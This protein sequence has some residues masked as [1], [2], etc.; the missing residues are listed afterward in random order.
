MTTGARA[1][2]RDSAPPASLLDAVELH[3]RA[4]AAAAARRVFTVPAEGAEAALRSASRSGARYDT[5]LSFMCTPQVASLE[6][7][8]AAIE[9]ILADEGWIGMVEPAGIDRG[10]L[11]GWLTARLRRQL[12]PRRATGRDAV[13]AVRA[14][15]LVITDI[16]RREARS[17]PPAWRQ[18]VVLRARRATP[19]PEGP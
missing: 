11:P 18:Y 14:R 19:R 13:S 3:C 15:G 17:V 6:D 5:V 4:L 16:Q 7:Y 9:L 8:V 2:E 1:V 10:W 12:P